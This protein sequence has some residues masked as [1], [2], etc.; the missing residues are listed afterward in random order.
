MFRRTHLSEP[1][2]FTV[3]IYVKHI[4]NYRHRTWLS[5]N[6]LKCT[7]SIRATDEQLA[8]LAGPKSLES[9]KVAD[10]L[11][12][13][14]YIDKWIKVWLEHN[15]YTSEELPL[16]IGESLVCF[17]KNFRKFKR[18]YRVAVIDNDLMW[19]VRH[20]VIAN[21]PN[22]SIVD[23]YTV[24]DEVFRYLWSLKPVPLLVLPFIVQ[25]RRIQLF[26]IFADHYG[27]EKCLVAACR[28]LWVEGVQ[29]CVDNGADLS[30]EDYVCLS[31]LS[32]DIFRI[33]T[34]AGGHATK[35]G[36]DEYIFQRMLRRIPDPYLVE[37]FFWIHGY[38]DP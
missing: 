9:L 3:V 22:W 2:S 33:V 20:N 32:A 36:Y 10:F 11:G 19:L 28:N 12:K 7:V 27:L 24:T 17:K 14:D 8:H 29:Y 21:K 1:T 25:P 13:Q 15:Q 23:F 4:R 34:Q 31:L 6:M 26:Q 16:C 5:G 35:M 30:Q 37:E 38:K 18:R